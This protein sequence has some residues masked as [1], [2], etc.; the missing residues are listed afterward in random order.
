MGYE[1]KI[2]NL[3]KTVQS[4][5]DTDFISITEVKA[6]DKLIDEIVSKLSVISDNSSSDANEALNIAQEIKRIEFNMADAINPDGSLNIS[7]TPDPV[8]GEVGGPVYG[9]YSMDKMLIKLDNLYNR[10]TKIVGEHGTEW[11]ID[12]D[13]YYNTVFNDFKNTV[14]S[15]FGNSVNSEAIE[16]KEN[17]KYDYTKR[18]AVKLESN[19]IMRLNPDVT[20]YPRSINILLSKPNTDVIAFEV[21]ELESNNLVLNLKF[22]NGKNYFSY[23]IIIDNDELFITKEESFKYNNYT[24][25][26]KLFKYN[27]NNSNKYIVTLSS[28]CSDITVKYGFKIEG[29]LVGTYDF[30]TSG[31]NLSDHKNSWNYELVDKNVVEVPEYDVEYWYKEEIPISDISE[32]SSESFNWKNVKGLRYWDEKEYYIR[33]SNFVEVGRIEIDN[34][35]DSGTVNLDNKDI[36]GKDITNETY[37]TIINKKKYTKPLYY[38]KVD[39]DT[40]E[41]FKGVGN[42]ENFIKNNK[43]YRLDEGA[44][45]I[46]SDNDV[47]YEKRDGKRNIDGNLILAS[48]NRIISLGTIKS[49]SYVEFNDTESTNVSNELFTPIEDQSL[50][51]DFTDNS[52][53][54]LNETA[55]KNT[56]GEDNII[57]PVILDF[58]DFFVNKLVISSNNNYLFDSKLQEIIQNTSENIIDGIKL[59]I[60][61]DNVVYVMP[62]YNKIIYDTNNELIKDIS[63]LVLNND[64]YKGIT[65]DVISLNYKLINFTNNLDDSY[66]NLD[67]SKYRLV[68]DSEYSKL[69]DFETESKGISN[70]I[71]EYD[72]INKCFIKDSIL[73]DLLLNVPYIECIK[74]IDIG[75]CIRDESLLEFNI[76]SDNNNE[77]DGY[78][79]IYNNGENDVEFPNIMNRKDY[80]STKEIPMSFISTASNEHLIYSINDNGKLYYST[81]GSSWKEESRVDYNKY[82]SF[83]YIEYDKESLWFALCHSAETDKIELVYSQ[84]GYDWNLVERGNIIGSNENIIKFKNVAINRYFLGTDKYAYFSEDGINWIKTN[85]PTGEWRDC[86]WNTKKFVVVG[87]IGAYQVLDGMDINTIANGFTL[88]TGSN[89]DWNNVATYDDYRFVIC[90]RSGAMYSDI[91]LYTWQRSD[92]QSGEFDCLTTIGN[93]VIAGGG[94]DNGI[95]YSEDNGKTWNSSNIQ[96]GSF[97]YLTTIGNTVIAGSDSNKGIYYS[98]DNGKTWNSSNIQSGSFYYLTTIGNTVIAGSSNN[99]LYYS[100]DNGKT[101]IRSNITSGDFKC[102]SVIGSTVIAGGHNNDGLYYSEDN[103]HTWKRSN[104]QT[105]DFFC[106]TTIGSTIIAGGW[107]NNG[108]YYSEDNGKTWNQSNI[109]FYYFF[110]LTT[111]GNTV[112]AGSGSDKGLY[113]SE[114]NG[115]TWQLS[116][117]TSGNFRCLTTIGSTVIA[118]SNSGKGLYYSE[119]NG[120]TWKQSNIQWDNIICLTVIGSTVIASDGSINVLYYSDNHNILQ[121]PGLILFT[122]NSDIG[123]SGAGFSLAN[124]KL[125]ISGTANNKISGFVD[126]HNIFQWHSNI[127]EVG[128]YSVSYS[129]SLKIYVGGSINNKGLW[130]SYDGRYWMQSNITTG[131]FTEHIYFD[132]ILSLFISGSNDKIVYSTDGRTWSDSNIISGITHVRKFHRFKD[133]VCVGTESGGD[134]YSTDGKTWTRG[135]ITSSSEVNGF[136]SNDTTLVAIGNTGIYY[137]T[138]TPD[139]WVKC[140]AGDNI[141]FTS[142]IYDNTNNKFYASATGNNDIY[143]SSNGINWSTVTTSGPKGLVA[144]NGKIILAFTRYVTGSIQTPTAQYSIDGGQ[145]WSDIR[146]LLNNIAS[147]YIVYNEVNETW[148]AAYVNNTNGIVYSKNG[149]DW[150]LLFEPTPTSFTGKTKL[151]STHAEDD[152]SEYVLGYFFIVNGKDIHRSR[153]GHYW[154]KISY[155]SNITGLSA[156]GKL[157]NRDAF[158]CLEDKGIL[159]STR[160]DEV[161]NGKFS[162]YGEYF[163]QT[164]ITDGTYNG[165]IQTINSDTNNTAY[166]AQ[167]SNSDTKSIRIN[168]AKNSYIPITFKTGDKISFIGDIGDNELIA[169][170]NIE[171]LNYDRYDRAFTPNV[172]VGNRNINFIKRI[173]DKTTVLGL[174]TS[175]VFT[176]E[177]NNNVYT[178]SDISVSDV[179]VTTNGIYGLNNS[180][181]MF[182]ITNPDSSEPVFT[183]VFST[184]STYNIRNIF[185]YSNRD[186]LFIAY[187]NSK[188]TI[189]RKKYDET[190]IESLG[191]FAGSISYVDLIDDNLVL[192]AHGLNNGTEVNYIQNIFFNNKTNE[193]VI[194]EL[195]DAEKILNFNRV[196]KYKGELFVFNKLEETDSQISINFGK[197]ILNGDGTIT[198]K[199]SDNGIIVYNK[200]EYNEDK[201][202]KW[203][204]FIYNDKL[205]FY[206]YCE[207][208][209]SIAEDIKN[210]G[211]FT[212]EDTESANGWNIIKLDNLLSEI[213]DKL[214]TDELVVQESLDNSLIIP[215]ENFRLDIDSDSKLYKND[216]IYFDKETEGLILGKYRSNGRF[217]LYTETVT[218]V[219]SETGDNIN[220]ALALGPDAKIALY[221]KEYDFLKVL[222]FKYIAD[223]NGS[224]IPHYLNISDSNEAVITNI[225]SGTK[226]S[227]NWL[228]FVVKDKFKTVTHDDYGNFI[229]GVSDTVSLRLFRTTISSIKADIKANN[230][231]I[232]CEWISDITGLDNIENIKIAFSKYGITKTEPLVIS[233]S[234]LQFLI[235]GKNLKYSNVDSIAS[236]NTNTACLIITSKIIWDSKFVD[237]IE[238][239]E[240]INNELNYTK[241]VICSYDYNKTGKL[242]ANRAISSFLL[243][244]TEPNGTIEHT[245][246]TNKPN[247]SMIN[248][249]KRIFNTCKSGIKYTNSGKNTTISS[250]YPDNYLSSTDVELESTFMPSKIIETKQGGLII[251]TVSTSNINNGGYLVNKYNDKILLDKFSDGNVFYYNDAKDTEIGLFRWFNSS[252]NS[253]KPNEF[254]A[255]S[256]ARNTGWLYFTPKNCGRIIRIDLGPNNYVY[257]IFETYAGIFISARSIVLY[258]DNTTTDKF[259]LYRLKNIPNT[260]EMVQMGDSRYFQKCECGNDP[261]IDLKD[262]SEGIFMI[263]F[264][265]TRTRVFKWNGEDF[266]AIRTDLNYTTGIKRIFDTSV[267]VFFIGNKAEW[268]LLK[269]IPSSDRLVHTKYKVYLNN[270]MSTVN[271]DSIETER[272]IY[273][274]GTKSGTTNN[275]VIWDLR[276]DKCKELGDIGDIGLPKEIK[277]Y[278]YPVLDENGNEIE[279]EFFT[280][281]NYFKKLSEKLSKS[282]NLPMDTWVK[283]IG[284]ININGI[285]VPI[286]G[287]KIVSGEGVGNDEPDNVIFSID[288]NARFNEITSKLIELPKDGNISGTI[289]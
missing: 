257:N 253:Y 98:E 116:N 1:N 166:I 184:L 268:G 100:E 276:I 240:D 219:K 120:K 66:N 92:I 43:F 82:D 263:A 18:S 277:I 262:T 154:Q 283:T 160:N 243:L 149:I 249:G 19:E 280:Y 275:K 153:D 136:A 147:W 250:R 37:S 192:L 232:T 62:K 148:Y 137:T 91:L 288:Q 159:V 90:G 144:S 58:V 247:N 77:N 21:N 224:G 53:G 35:E 119:D 30:S 190:T 61:S 109:I 42:R 255:N 267:G 206:N 3:G 113:Y 95:Y 204:G 84:N 205:Y 138:S 213:F 125:F 9:E 112:I 31:F 48:G 141:D 181:G 237:I 197:L 260:I 246:V 25:T 135:D 78:K 46:H 72:S 227:E 286:K 198:L 287:M 86:A 172:I 259:E 222:D 88:C 26:I 24:Y 73:R 173:T 129:P 270:W 8:T 115:H 254:V 111:I 56:Y 143:I 127:N 101:W 106:L 229:V 196:I 122:R 146:G 284:N 269:Y 226:E 221:D 103:G 80:T 110:S 248:I 230:E 123:F 169:V 239:S 63:I 34:T 51:V 156:V 44:K 152:T 174:D 207:P 228:Y 55:L 170:D 29:L 41:I 79:F 289:V 285:E 242:D 168:E 121:N 241:S 165:I 195:I 182:E 220:V 59:F 235:S 191:E 94:S 118:G 209:T 193:I 223:I 67:L 225:Y 27:I 273:V 272:G 185:E 217:N 96:S 47:I 157:T 97:Y 252:L 60:D 261:V 177:L 69:I 124:N 176:T 281:N 45:F 178:K 64:K 231:K 186:L 81:N 108:L 187:K 214:F 264:Y 10:F 32:T 54:H 40:S 76:I 139:S 151:I 163:K 74:K 104:I 16:E 188:Y 171:Y 142:V 212:I 211:L 180:T 215:N 4:V 279:Y 6:F 33:Q 161:L 87:S 36:N 114:D 105:G 164:Y 199:N 131:G 65:N 210:K 208:N 258:G 271:I 11:K 244:N 251:D 134:Y 99:G 266:Y 68:I 75:R 167:S 183:E 158:L 28:D 83:S 179:V 12:L 155:N 85:I 282:Y 202:P 5:R 150:Q 117:I 233:N 17:S 145:T 130:Y 162:T 133:Y 256:D 216:K 71:L 201:Y 23:N 128:I 2:P 194:Q 20:A 102:L 7:S 70:S 238:Q 265:N 126:T 218:A 175:L 132:N 203:N 245:Y 140:S 236:F 50:Y 22:L 274:T 107:S 57:V 93:T 39:L 14:N 13:N 15:I 49:K 189:F 278:P 200:N 38:T 234:D 52:D 89:G